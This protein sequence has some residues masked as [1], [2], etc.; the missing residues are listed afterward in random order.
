MSDTADYAITVGDT[1]PVIEETLFDDTL[2]TLEGASVQFHV[3]DDSR[4]T[5]VDSPATIEDARSGEV[6]YQF[7]SGELTETGL[8]RAEFEV[9][10]SDG[11]VQTFPVGERIHIEV[12]PALDG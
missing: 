1:L 9:T 8:Y 11:D 12:W 4:N 7:G 3:R 10:F 6:S 5:V 2:K